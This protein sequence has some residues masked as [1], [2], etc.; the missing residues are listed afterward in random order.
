M[1]N[2]FKTIKTNDVEKILKNESFSVNKT[3]ESIVYERNLGQFY[4]R[5]K[6]HFDDNNIYQMDICSGHTHIKPDEKQIKSNFNNLIALINQLYENN[7][8]F[9]K[10]LEKAT[11]ELFEK[12]GIHLLI[13]SE[14]YCIRGINSDAEKELLLEENE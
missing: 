10:I 3:N 9:K 12:K 4:D 1:E 7:P 2:L 13:E 11:K 14:K 5:I 6:I 8:L